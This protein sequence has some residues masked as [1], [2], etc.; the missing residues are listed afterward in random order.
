MCASGTA[1]C[2]KTV[3]HGEVDTPP[4]VGVFA[5]D[6]QRSD[7]AVRQP[8]SPDVTGHVVEISLPG[9]SLKGDGVAMTSRQRRRMRRHPDIISL[10]ASVLTDHEIQVAAG[11]RIA[12]DSVVDR[13]HMAS[14]GAW[15]TSVA[16]VRRDIADLQAWCRHGR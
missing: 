7:T 4:R 9:D 1:P 11:G 5:N 14:I 8:F 6:G 16:G 15:D 10:A 3:G 13:V 2:R 12:P